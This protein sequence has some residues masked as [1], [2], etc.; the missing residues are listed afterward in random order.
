MPQCWVW[1]DGQEAARFSHKS[2]RGQVLQEWRALWFERDE[3]YA[4]SLEVWPC[5]APQTPSVNADDVHVVG[6]MRKKKSPANVS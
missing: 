6:Q 4:V 1:E 5:C 2:A 3:H